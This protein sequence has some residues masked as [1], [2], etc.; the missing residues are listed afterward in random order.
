MRS[1]S[2]YPADME[3]RLGRFRIPNDRLRREPEKALAILAGCV[4]VR[5]EALWHSDDVEYMACHAAFGPVPLGAE[6]PFY[7]WAMPASGRDCFWIRQ[8]CP[9]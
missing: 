3:R 5:A 1:V 6:P 8:E 4:V 2:A 9:P 7:A